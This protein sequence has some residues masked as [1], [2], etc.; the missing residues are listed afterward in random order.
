MVLIVPMGRQKG[1][2]TSNKNPKQ[3]TTFLIIP[4]LVQ[5]SR[6][7]QIDFP[8]ATEVGR[9]NLTHHH[10]NKIF[11]THPILLQGDIICLCYLLNIKQLLCSVELK[12]HGYYLEHVFYLDHVIFTNMSNVYYL[13]QQVFKSHEYYIFGLCNRSNRIDAGIFYTVRS[14][15][16]TRSRHIACVS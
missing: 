15:I 8:E 11:I 13:A 12:P 5:F 4:T 10:L 9:Y 3:S 16:D 6:P 2:I 14:C 7:E 1:K